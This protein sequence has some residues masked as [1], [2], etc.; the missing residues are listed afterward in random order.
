MAYQ[1][2]MNSNTG[3]QNQQYQQGGQYS[4][5]GY[6]NQYPYSGQQFNNQ[7]QFPNTNQFNQGDYQYQVGPGPSQNNQTQSTRS[8]SPE[9][10]SYGGNNGQNN[11][12]G[13]LNDGFSNYGNRSMARRSLLGQSDDYRSRRNTDRGNRSSSPPAWRGSGFPNRKRTRAERRA[14]A[15]S[16][17]GAKRRKDTSSINLKEE[18][19]SN[20]EEGSS[21]SSSLR[22]NIAFSGGTDLLSMADVTYL[23]D[24]LSQA[25]IDDTFPENPPSTYGIILM[26]SGVIR[27]NCKD[28]TSVTTLKK[29][30]AQLPARPDAP[31]GYSVLGPQDKPKERIFTVWIPSPGLR[32]NLEKILVVLTRQNPDVPVND[33]RIVSVV[34][35]DTDHG[36]HMRVAVKVSALPSLSKVNFR[37]SFLFGQILLNGNQKIDA[38]KGNEVPEQET[39]LNTKDVPAETG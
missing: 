29:W 37:L 36:F 26:K 6:G 16:T 30:V 15:R 8:V 18:G 20:K 1:G 38:E 35:K 9:L 12:K 21:S 4:N 2:G 13:D 32:H 7:M 19:G 39:N 14:A 17:N 34:G 27:I 3:W 24:M 23:N 28:E 5:Q 31:S 25:M 33:I 22:L 10:G 11:L